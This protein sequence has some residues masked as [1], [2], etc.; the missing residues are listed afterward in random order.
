MP[1]EDERSYHYYMMIN[2]FDHLDINQERVHLP[3]GNAKDLRESCRK[4]EQQIKNAGGIDLQVLGIGTN[5][6]IGFN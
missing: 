3:D 2:L 6:H 5:G 4:Y 1:R